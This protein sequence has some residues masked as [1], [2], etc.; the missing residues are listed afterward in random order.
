MLIAILGDVHSNREALDVVLTD[1]LSGGVRCFLQ[2]GDI[3]GYGPDPGY[4]IER[5]REL[6]SRICIGNHDAAVIGQLPLELFNPFARQA[7]EWTRSELNTAEKAYLG[8]LPLVQELPEHGIS[9]VHG[10][11]YQPSNFDYVRS[12][13]SARLSLL[14]QASDLCFVGHTH[15]PCLF[16]YD[17]EALD[18]VP[19]FERNCNHILLSGQKVLVNVGSVGQPRDENPRTAYVLFDS[20]RRSLD[21]IRLEYDIHRVQA[22]I[23][24]K[25]LPEVLAERLSFGL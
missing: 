24:E 6:D 25:G 2:V 16:T 5:L 19:E 7:L 14:E 11:L 21:L 17:G 12:L 1:A 8:D 3:V 22:K 13:T 23:R 20:Q 15:Q 18:Y 9:I 10:S 4:C